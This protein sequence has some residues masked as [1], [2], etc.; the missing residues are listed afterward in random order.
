MCEPKTTLEP[1]D[2]VTAGPEQQA[3]SADVA[4]QPSTPVGP[5]AGVWTT[6][7]QALAGQEHDYTTGPIGRAV[8][9]LAIPMVLEMLMESTFAIC[10]VFFVSRLGIDAVAAVG[11]TE[12]VLTLV[13]AVAAG[14]SM[15]A[16]AMVARRI[17]EGEMREGDVVQFPD[18]GFDRLG[19]DVASQQARYPIA[20]RVQDQEE[21]R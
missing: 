10:D 20:D 6:V 14:M 21:G 5:P 13:Y 1:A 7:R 16:T 15:S 3:A 12:A 8:V 19:R 17:G 11:L 18:R 4:Q 2:G 9:L